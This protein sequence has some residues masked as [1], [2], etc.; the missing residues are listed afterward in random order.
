MALNTAKQKLSARSDWWAVSWGVLQA[1]NT[2]ERVETISQ[3]ILVPKQN[4]QQ[5]AG[6]PGEILYFQLV[7]CPGRA[8]ASP[9]PATACPWPTALLSSKSSAF[10]QVQWEGQSQCAC[11]LGLVLLDVPERST[12]HKQASSAAQAAFRT[13]PLLSIFY[14]LTLASWVWTLCPSLEDD[15]TLHKGSH[16]PC[17]HQ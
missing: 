9:T 11:A 17:K 12:V 6:Y 2:T 5:I 14:Q 16:T 8:W 13:K 15:T 7:L 3:H 10:G 4:Y 1:Y